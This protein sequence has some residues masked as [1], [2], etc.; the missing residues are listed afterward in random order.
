MDR[1]G[2][3]P[4]APARWPV[5]VV[6]ALALLVLLTLANA[7]GTVSAWAEYGDR[8]ENGRP[9]ASALLTALVATVI[10]AGNAVAALGFLR[11]RN[12]ARIL[13]LAVCVAAGAGVLA[14][15]VT[16]PEPYG[17][18]GVGLYVALLAL[19]L[20]GAAKTWCG[21]PTRKRGTRT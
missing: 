17:L 13:G 18:I 1:G 15:V 4:A 2:S 9:L 7:T 12:W 11:H 19:L 3:A 14:T 21:R 20:T 8:V 16:G 6:I 10:A 5:P